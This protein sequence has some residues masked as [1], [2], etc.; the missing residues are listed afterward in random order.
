MNYKVYYRNEC[1]YNIERTSEDVGE[2]SDDY[3]D[4]YEVVKGFANAKQR[5]CEII[6]GIIDELKDIKNDVKSRT[7]KDL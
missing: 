3:G 7:L 2:Y 1:E 6:D 4:D 5:F